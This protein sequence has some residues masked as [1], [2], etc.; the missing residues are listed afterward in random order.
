MV[1]ALSATVDVSLDRALRRRGFGCRGRCRSGAALL[2]RETV[3]RCPA[4]RNSEKS[5]TLLLA[6]A[7]R[8]SG[9]KLPGRT[10][11]IVA[12]SSAS[13]KEKSRKKALSDTE[14]TAQQSHL[15][16]VVYVSKYD[17]SFFCTIL[18]CLMSLSKLSAIFSNFCFSNSVVGAGVFLR[19]S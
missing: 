15:L 6:I 12:K 14:S 18:I 9:A 7:I 2:R 1:D 8:T 17:A 11:A 16:S 3:S 19:A 5:H 10:D 4:P 13:T